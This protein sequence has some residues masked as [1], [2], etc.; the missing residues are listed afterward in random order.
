MEKFLNKSI[1]EL[2]TSHPIIGKILQSYNIDCANC[3]LASCALKDVLEIHSLKEEEA[4]ELFSKLGSVLMPNEKFVIPKFKGA[5][6]QNLKS[7]SPPMKILVDEHVLIKSFVALIPLMKKLDKKLVLDSVEFIKFY[8]DKYHHMKEE[9]ILFKF[10]D[11]NLTILQVMHEDHKKG[12]GL[13]KKILESLDIDDF[14]TISQCLK[15]YHDLLSEHIKKEDE[16]LFPW[17]DKNLTMHQ[18]GFFYASCKKI[19]E[20]T[21][22]KKIIWC[23]N[24]IKNLQKELNV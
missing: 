6:T 4:K 13:V 12:R 10:F 7:F 11:E 17:L 24:F 3:S 15:D 22:Q 2:I 14:E 19:E 16:V 18:I 1:K 21:D 8:A 20:E 23:H 5:K 9:D